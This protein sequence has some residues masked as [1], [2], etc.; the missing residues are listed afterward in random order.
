ML[1]ISD[2][3][4]FNPQYFSLR[5]QRTKRIRMM[6]G[7]HSVN[8][9]KYCYNELICILGWMWQSVLLQ[10]ISNIKIN[11]LKSTNVEG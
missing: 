7:Q 6:E 8:S 9:L 2:Q 4:I 10:L 11:K 3:F 1:I 5:L